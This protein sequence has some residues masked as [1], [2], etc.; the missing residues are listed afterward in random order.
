MGLAANGT[1]VQVLP[2][3]LREPGRSSLAKGSGG[4]QDAGAQANQDHAQ[5]SEDCVGWSRDENKSLSLFQRLIAQ[6]A[7]PALDVTP[8]GGE[9]KRHARQGIRP[10]RN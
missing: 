8:W 2:R 1:R 10:R 9:G 3:P 7:R 4:R 5:G 6:V